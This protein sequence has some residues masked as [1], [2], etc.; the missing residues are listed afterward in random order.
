MPGIYYGDHEPRHFQE[1]YSGQ[2]ASLR[3]QLSPRALGLAMEWAALHQIEL[4]EDWKLARAEAQLKPIDP[5][6]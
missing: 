4:M 1:R 3:G 2:K 5:L 6:E